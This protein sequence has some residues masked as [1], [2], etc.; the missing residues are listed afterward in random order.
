MAAG[1]PRLFFDADALFA[2]V[3]SPMG[4]AGALLQAAERREVEVVVSPQAL[5]E[6]E[7]NLAEKFPLSRPDFDAALTRVPFVRVADPAAKDREARLRYAEAN[8]AAHVA[9]A[10]RARCSYLVT[11]NLRDYRVATIEAELGLRVRRPGDVLDELRASGRLTQ[12][13]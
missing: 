9:A 1:R 12:A 4:G 5:A 3:H 10:H 11:Y 6:A 2:G 7:R 13:A 8:D